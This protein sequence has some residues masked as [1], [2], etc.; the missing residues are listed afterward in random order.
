M[1]DSDF[2]ISKFDQL[3]KL[4]TAYMNLHPS[5]F[6]SRELRELDGKEKEVEAGGAFCDALNNIGQALAFPKYA[7]HPKSKTPNWPSG[8]GK[9]AYIWAA[10]LAVARSSFDIKTGKA[11]L[12]IPALQKANQTN[13]KYESPRCKN[14]ILSI[15]AGKWIEK[16]G[17]QDVLSTERTRSQSKSSQVVED[18]RTAA[19]VELAKLPDSIK[20][21]EIERLVRQR[22]GQDR[23][24]HAM[25]D[26]WGNA[27]SVMGVAVPEAL[28]ASHAKPWAD[29]T[30]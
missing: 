20:G 5:Y 28:R 7:Y 13:V 26:Y 17:R 16:V 14:F 6:S 24:R 15:E 23:F 29:C 19:E 4:A 11:A 9:D 1:N 18:Y 8:I 10:V 22:V 25:L 3:K 30:I 21:T 27:C 2:S 12:D